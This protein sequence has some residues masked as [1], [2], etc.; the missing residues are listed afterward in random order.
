MDFKKLEPGLLGGSVFEIL[1]SQRIRTGFI[2]ESDSET[3]AKIFEKLEWHLRVYRELPQGRIQKYSHIYYILYHINNIF[4]DREF[5]D[6]DFQ[7]EEREND[8]RSGR[9]GPQ[10]VALGYKVLG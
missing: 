8:F 10:A 5:K 7:L 9:E 1:K 6:G 2:G 4:C 3:K